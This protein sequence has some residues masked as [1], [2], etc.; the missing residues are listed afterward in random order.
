M[1][2]SHML[3]ATYRSPHASASGRI[4]NLAQR[5]HSAMSSIVPFSESI[6]RKKRPLFTTR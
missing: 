6:S 5:E 3:H 4:V 1:T 2:V